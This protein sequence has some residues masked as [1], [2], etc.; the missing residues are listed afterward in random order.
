LAREHASGDLLITP[1]LAELCRL[2]PE[3]RERAPDLLVPS[4][5]EAMARPR[6]FEAIV[7][8][9]QALAKRMP[10]IVFIDDLHWA[11]ASSLDLLHYLSRSSAQSKMPILLLFSLRSEAL[12]ITSEL[13]DW[14]SGLG[15]DLPVTCL[16]LGPLTVEGTV[17]LIGSLAHEEVSGQGQRSAASRLGHW[18]HA[19]TGGQPFFLME[20]LKT[21]V[22][23]GILAVHTAEDGAPAIDIAPALHHEHS[24]RGILP[25]GVREMIR[26]RL[27]RLAPRDLHVLTAG[28][29]L[30]KSFTFEWLC[31]VANLSENEGLP[32]LE[33]L[34]ISHLLSE[35]RNEGSISGEE[36]FLFAHDKIRDVVYTEAGSTR[37]RL[38]H[39]RALETLQ[40]AS[41]SPAELAHHARASGQAP[42]AL[43]WSIAA[44]DEAMRL[45]D[46]FFAETAN[47]GDILLR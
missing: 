39:R 4:S 12:A 3:L 17:Q 14:L 20:T 6:L 30:G 45:V 5:D 23:C 21:L 42:A 1:W 36:R 2:L 15:R 9:L 47:N 28:A 13:A 29:A 37:R 44:G 35:V 10:L 19:E 40:A 18:L 41:A 27:A 7:R 22:E 43:R 25:P 34:L 24:L 16:E 26:S 8:L 11:D 38:F 46:D 31:R 32:A 33:A